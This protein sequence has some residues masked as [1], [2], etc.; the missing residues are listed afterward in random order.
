MSPGMAKPPNLNNPLA[1]AAALGLAEKILMCIASKTVWERAG[2]TGP[3]VIAMMV[4]ELI[5]HDAGF[6][7][8]W[9]ASS[10]P[11]NA[12]RPGDLTVQSFEPRIVCN[13]TLSYVAE[14]RPTS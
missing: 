3:T 9:T 8:P 10:T 14:Q 13:A 7:P 11:I 6:P 4:K 5:E 2:I 1:Q 12:D